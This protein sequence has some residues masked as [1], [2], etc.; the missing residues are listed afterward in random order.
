MGSAGR[1]RDS[2][3]PWLGLLRKQ[4][5]ARTAPVAL[6]AGRDPGERIASGGG[7]ACVPGRQRQGLVPLAECW[8]R[9]VP[10]PSWRPPVP[11]FPR[12]ASPVPHPRPGTARVPV[13]R[14]KDPLGVAV[15][16]R[17]GRS[18]QWGQSLL[19]QTPP[20]EPSPRAGIVA[21]AGRGCPVAVRPRA[22]ACAPRPRCGAAQVGA[23]GRLWGCPSSSPHAR[24]R[25]RWPVAPSSDPPET[26]G[27]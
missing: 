18:G 23:P 14:F 21:A 3:V 20:P 25:G 17:T 12:K 5:R 16:L 4:G 19:P 24:A 26:L 1:G 13:P 11:S 22:G 8:P 6:G 7:G 10:A 9:P 27:A 2:K 15:R